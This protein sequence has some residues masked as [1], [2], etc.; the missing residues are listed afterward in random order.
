MLAIPV[1]TPLSFAFYSPGQVL[2]NLC[3]RASTGSENGDYVAAP[4]SPRPRTPLI[5][6]IVLDA[7]RAATAVESRDH[8]T[9]ARQT[10]YR[11]HRSGPG[12]GR[13]RLRSVDGDVL[14][15]AAA[16]DLAATSGLRTRGLGSRRTP[17]RR[18]RRRGAAPPRSAARPRQLP[19][20]RARLISGSFVFGV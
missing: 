15:D 12:G 8:H 1:K 20:A 14:S 16:R 6:A 19:R 2:R 10:P 7:A 5:P 13:L 11:P 18:R 3:R 17:A 9:R 4:R